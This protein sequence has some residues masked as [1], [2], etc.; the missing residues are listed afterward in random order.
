[1][2]DECKTKEQLLDEV[3]ALRQRVAE[4]ERS[5]NERRLGRAPGKGNVQAFHGAQSDLRL[6]KDT[7]HGE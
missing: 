4:L 1:M 7:G 6:F 2:E 3:I 5:E